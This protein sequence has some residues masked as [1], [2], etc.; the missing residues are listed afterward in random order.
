MY[1]CTKKRYVACDI[2]DS[3]DNLK[4]SQSVFLIV[5]EITKRETNK[6]KDIKYEKKELHID[7]NLDKWYHRYTQCCT[8]VISTWIQS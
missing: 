5:T 2:G 7:L 6:K 3:C 8:E 4:N 1:N